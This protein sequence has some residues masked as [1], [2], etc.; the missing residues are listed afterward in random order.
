MRVDR[1]EWRVAE[2]LQRGEAPEE[3]EEENDEGDSVGS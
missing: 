3:E 1:D 2:S